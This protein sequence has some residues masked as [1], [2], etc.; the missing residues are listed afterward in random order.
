MGLDDMVGKAKDMLSEHGEQIT[1]G[2]D[3]AADF[4]KERTD[5]EGDAKVDEVAEKA[6]DL[7]DDQQK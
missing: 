1:E 7:L 5:D 4:V 3:K 2:I 6:K